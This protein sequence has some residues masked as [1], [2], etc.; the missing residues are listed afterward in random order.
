MKE[1]DPPPMTDYVDKATIDS[2][3]KARKDPASLV[4]KAG[5]KDTAEQKAENLAKNKQRV[6]K[7]KEMYKMFVK[8]EKEQKGDEEEAGESDQDGQDRKDQTLPLSH[9]FLPKSLP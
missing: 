5:S 2:I 8:M 1:L 4:K 7:M 6:E 9:T 3:K